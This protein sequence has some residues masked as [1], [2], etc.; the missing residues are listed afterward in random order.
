MIFPS[1][2]DCIPF[3]RTLSRVIGQVESSKIWM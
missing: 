1:S 2:L 3:L